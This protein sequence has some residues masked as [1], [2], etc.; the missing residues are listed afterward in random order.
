MKGSLVIKVFVLI[1]FPIFYLCL[2]PPTNA[3]DIYS[4]VFSEGYYPNNGTGNFGAIV[5]VRKSQ[6]R[7]CAGEELGRY[8]GSTLPNPYWYYKDSKGNA[9]WK[10]GEIQSLFEALRKDA[11]GIN[12]SYWGLESFEPILNLFKEELPVV[13]SGEYSTNVKNSQKLG[14]AL[15]VNN[16]SKIRTENPNPTKHYYYEADGI[17]VHKGI[18]YPSGNKG[19]EGCITIHPKHWESFIAKFPSAGE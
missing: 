12:L 5:I 1:I 16:G 10:D 15:I 6:C 19:S 18:L 11:Q 8:R 13:S 7:N 4:V 14:K 17:W 2:T 3:S 9:L